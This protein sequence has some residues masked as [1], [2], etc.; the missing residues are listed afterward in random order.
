MAEL[1][2]RTINIWKSTVIGS[3]SAGGTS[4]SDPIDL[5]DISKQ[6]RFS[7]SY[8]IAAAGGVGTAASTVFTYLGCPVYDGTYV[9]P[10][11]GTCGTVNGVGSDIVS[12]S[13]PVM[14]FMKVKVVAGTS[15]TAL[16]TGALHVQ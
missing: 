11:G 8:S 14:P 15:G 10:T 12:I 16:V 2:I 7:L 1:S 9:T 4:L 3:G 6:G 13:P 5:R